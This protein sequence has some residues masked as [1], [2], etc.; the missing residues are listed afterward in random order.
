MPLVD[1]LAEDPALRNYHLLPAVRADL[2]LK[3]GR[4]TEAKAEF[5]KAAR[6]TRN[7]RE[8]ALLRAR[9]AKCTPSQSALA[10]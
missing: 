8:Q 3:L 1:E 6:I 4:G 9:A 5:E 2:L 7:V 10:Q